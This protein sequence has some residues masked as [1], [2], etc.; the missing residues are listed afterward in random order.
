[1]RRIA[2]Q[3]CGDQSTRACR[4]SFDHSREF[5]LIFGTASCT[6]HFPTIETDVLG[7]TIRPFRIQ[8]AFFAALQ[9]ESEARQHEHAAAFQ[10][11]GQFLGSFRRNNGV[12]A[13]DVERGQLGHGNVSNAEGQIR[14][15]KIRRRRARIDDLPESPRRQA[16]VRAACRLPRRPSARTSDSR[17]CSP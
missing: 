8:K 11:A 7:A 16:I 12:P 10:R 5:P 9:R 1:M 17:R 6:L 14:P 3:Q 15:S 2:R 4:E 13:R